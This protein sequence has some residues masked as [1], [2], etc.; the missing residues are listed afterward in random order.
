LHRLE[1][2]GQLQGF[3]SLAQ[4]SCALTRRQEG[5]AHGCFSPQRPLVAALPARND[6]PVL[7]CGRRGR[8][9]DD[10]SALPGH[11]Y[12]GCAP[13]GGNRVE[14]TGRPRLAQDSLTGT[15]CGSWQSDSVPGFAHGY[16]GP[17]AERERA[18][19]TRG[20]DTALHAAPSATVHRQPIR[21]QLIRRQP[22]RWKPSAH[23]YHRGSVSNHNCQ[24]ELCR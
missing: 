5:A 11:A 16:G 3:R 17:H 15:A 20:D 23:R 24:R 21:R 8:R 13:S 14:A 2:F 18:A 22:I 4:R 19:P 6:G 9:R 12:S 10:G 7:L 1:G